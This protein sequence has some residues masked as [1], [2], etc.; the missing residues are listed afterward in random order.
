MTSDAEVSHSDSASRMAIRVGVI[1]VCRMGQIAVGVVVALLLARHY[2]PEV[3]GG[4]S[5]AFAFAEIFE[6]VAVLGTTI[7]IT[8]Q[9]VLLKGVD[10]ADFW[11]NA[12]LVRVI[13]VTVGLV[14]AWVT[15][16]IFF[17][18][19]PG[20]LVMLLWAS[21][22]LITSLRVAYQAVLRARERADWSAGAN[23]GRSILYLSL[24][25]VVV[26]NDASALRVIQASLVATFV[27]VAWDRA[28]AR[29]FLV[30]GGK[31]SWSGMKSLLIRS[32]PLALSAILTVIQVRID[33]LMLKV[34][35]GD[36]AVGLYSAATRLTEAAY[37]APAALGVVVF[38]ALTRAFAS[39][40]SNLQ[41]FFSNIIVIMIALGLPFAI[42]MS[43]Y[44]DSVIMLLFGSEFA[45]SA[46]VL[47]VMSMQ[48][49]LGFVNIA[50]VNLLFAAE[51]Q[52]VEMWASVATT[53]VNVVANLALIP[54][55]G[56]VG[57]ALA[58]VLCQLVA[59]IVLWQMSSVVVTPAIP[60]RTLVTIGVLNLLMYL[61][62]RALD[63][64][65]PWIAAALTLSIAY[66]ALLMA[67][68]ID[69][70]NQIARLIKGRNEKAP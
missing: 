6:V 59:F 70:R 32:V 45:F 64:A 57:A 13:L 39:R 28:L 17:R 49:P 63:T 11:R 27:A 9:L 24:I 67:T 33:I 44:A 47:V 4:L 26:V 31:A 8:R 22:G 56:P 25:M 48:V 23:V 34:M 40:G 54:V 42:L 20:T 43:Y 3:Y 69:V 35:S 10:A 66:L 2:G 12:L 1:F 16:W 30:P 41:A 55:L 53:L 37:V 15:A 29:R 62:C 58:T 50:L 5:F 7:V 60:G 68:N 19:P 36:V 14:G 51:K 46:P 21:L 65:V 38:P 18:D 61:G 52:K